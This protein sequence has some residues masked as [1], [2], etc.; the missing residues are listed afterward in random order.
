M[1]ST[2]AIC[3]RALIRV[4][5]NT[6]S[7]FNDSL[8][9]ATLLNQIYDPIRKGLLRSHP[10]AFAME[11]SALALLNV[12]PAFKYDFSFQLPTDCLR[13]WDLHEANSPWKR[14]GTKLYTNDDAV[15]LIYIKDVTDP[16][17]FDTVFEDCLA[18]KIA[19]ELAYNITGSASML[20]PLEQEFSMRMKEAKL[21]DAQED[22]PEVWLDNGSWDGS[23]R[24]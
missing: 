5:A 20:G 19:I 3:N 12:A 15:N 9:E 22:F 4:G 14:F 6:I 16:A 23:R 7:S 17:Q 21:W 2:I 8:K 1:S 13:V 24:F 18:L 10:W 11:L